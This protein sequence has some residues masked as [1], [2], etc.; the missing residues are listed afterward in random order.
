MAG[1]PTIAT[2]AP[3]AVKPARVDIFAKPSPATSTA[4]DAPRLAGVFDAAAACEPDEGIVLRSG[5]AA[6]HVHAGRRLP[7]PLSLA[8]LVVAVVAVIFTALQHEA[9]S[10]SPIP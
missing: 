1:N 9:G 4:E 2:P 10:T 8:L 7:R 5:R 3:F 6:W